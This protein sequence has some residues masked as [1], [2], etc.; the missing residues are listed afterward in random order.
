MAADTAAATVEERADKGTKLVLQPEE[1]RGYWQP[2]PANGHIIIKVSPDNCTS[3]LVTMGIQAVAPEGCYV[4]EHWHS[5]NDEILFCYEGRGTI[6]VDGAPH[7]FVPGTTAYLGRWVKHKIVNDGDRPL[8]FTWTFL[9][10][11]LDE[12]FAS[13]GRPRTAG[14]PAPEPFERPSDHL[15]IEGRTGFG[16]PVGR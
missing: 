15:A 6:L 13:I 2:K 10:P 7:P 1:G 12:F 8:K 4:R 14:D 3:N 11:G 5:R 16:P 9:P